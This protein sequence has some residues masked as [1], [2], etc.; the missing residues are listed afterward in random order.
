MTPLL[1]YFYHFHPPTLLLL[2][3]VFNIFLLRLSKRV[4]ALAQS[5][6]VL[7]C[8]RVSSANEEKHGGF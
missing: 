3:P 4:N 8:E 1:I 7:T 5:R 6:R 2:P